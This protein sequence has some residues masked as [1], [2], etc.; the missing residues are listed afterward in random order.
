MS[1]AGDVEERVRQ[2][3]QLLDAGAGRGRRSRA[4]A[5]RGSP[6]SVRVLGRP[7]A[8]SRPRRRRR[9]RRAG[10]ARPRRRRSAGS[11]RRSRPGSAA[12]GGR[13]RRAPRAGPPAGRPSSVSASSA[14]RMVRPVKSTSS[15]STTTRPVTSTGTSV[16]PSGCDRAQADVV[17]V[18]GDVERADRDRRRPR[19]TRSRRRGGGRS[20]GR[21]CSRPTSTRSSAPW[22]RSTISCAMRVCARRRSVGV[23]APGSG[24]RNDPL[25]RGSARRIRV[26]RWR[27]GLSAM[28][29][30]PWGPHRSPLTASMPRVAAEPGLRT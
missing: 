11:C 26:R 8:R 30:P 25:A 15:T 13:G 22:L 6:P 24:T 7:R 10:P 5:S 18:E 23:E 17:A 14:A 29:T 9:S 28:R 12:R 20:P 2:V 4:G 1:R 21:G 27:A 16:G 19:T 3:E